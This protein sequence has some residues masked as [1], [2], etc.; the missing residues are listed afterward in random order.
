MVSFV[1]QTTSEVPKVLADGAG[2]K[3]KRFDN[4]NLVRYIE[5]F[6]AFRE[7]G[8]GKLVAACYNTSLNPAVIPAPQ[9]TAPQAMV[10]GLDFAKLKD[11]YRLLGASLNGPKLWMLDWI[12][13]EVG[14]TRGFNGMKAPW[15][16]QLKMDKNA[17][18]SESTPYKPLTIARKSGAGWNKGT[19]ALLLDDA[20]GN[21]WIMKGVPARRQ[22]AIYIRAVF[23]GKLRQFQ[24]APA[25]LEVSYQ[26]AG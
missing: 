8:T 2:A 6:L 10:E 16:A 14:V 12:E 9:D 21:T 20:E 26:D 23:R 13:V 3:T 11:E 19:T 22:T 1:Q 25:G 18:V 7:A 15:V 17:S 5:M 4:L 24:E